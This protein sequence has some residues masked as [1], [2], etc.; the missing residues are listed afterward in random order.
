MDKEIS[1]EK[2]IGTQ[3]QISILYELLKKRSYNISH[4]KMPTIKEHKIFVQNN[5]YRDWYIVFYKG[6]TIGSFYIKYDNSIGIKI[7]KQKTNIVKHIIDFIYSNFEPEES[8]PSEIPPYFYFN[9]SYDNKE[10]KD[11]FKNI[12]LKPFQ[13]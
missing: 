2:F 9:V 3:E 13:T 6:E 5:R 11:C 7:S 8:I 1:L 4:K 12:S 10:L